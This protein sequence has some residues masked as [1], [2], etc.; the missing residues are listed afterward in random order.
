MKGTRFF[1]HFVSTIVAVL[2]A[3]LS[4]QVSAEE[5]L[6][7]DDTVKRH[8]RK[9]LLQ[10]TDI[11]VTKREFHFDVTYCGHKAPKCHKKGAW[12]Y[13]IGQSLEDEMSNVLLTRLS[14]KRYDALKIKDKK[15]AIETIFEK[16]EI[17][18]DID[19][20]MFDVGNGDDFI[21]KAEAYLNKSIAPL[22]LRLLDKAKDARYQELP[23]KEKETFLATIAKEESVPIKFI[24]SLMSSAYVFTLHMDSL[25]GNV[26]VDQEEKKDSQGR[27]YMVYDTT[28]KVNTNVN[29]LI[30]NFNPNLKKFEFYSKVA[31]RS[32]SV[33][34]SADF[35]HYPD[36]GNTVSLFNKAVRLSA[37]ASGL[38]ANTNLKD[39]DNFAIF[40]TVDQLDGNKIESRIGDVEDLRIDAPY[41]LYQQQDGKRVLVGWVK[42]RSVATEQT[43]KEDIGN[44][45]SKFDL[46]QGEA[47][48]SDSM[49]EHPWTGIF[50]YAGLANSTVT[51]TELDGQSATGGGAYNALNL[52]AK[53]DLGYVFNSASQTEKWLEFNSSFGFGGEDLKT[54]IGNFQGTMAVSASIDLVKRSYMG[55]SGAYWGYKYGIGYSSLSGSR[56]L[57]AENLTVSSYGLNLGLQ[58][59]Y[60][61]SADRS[62]YINVNYM[63]PLASGAS[64]GPTDNPVN[65]DA[66]LSP[67][68]NL[69]VGA[70]FHLRSVG[71]LAGF[72]L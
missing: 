56:V 7:D 34:A 18:S 62:Y 10:L 16:L 68:L 53:L 37:K 19:N 51:L 20:F 57:D 71:S 40:A 44:Y 35:D 3:Q 55:S 13:K 9:V 14:G 58:A 2:I 54:N 70:T 15:I 38:A 26:S 72:M 32:G 21:A 23:D 42:A 61:T 11:G 28:V 66:S 17:D 65:F 48:I 25:T 69:T 60:Q 47:E 67:T 46:I 6:A 27:H 41:N 8:E 63:L 30:F 29:L 64:L 52:G 45:S 1:K 59:G 36:F 24:K 4:F 33:Y 39:D 50:W 49:R 5:L 43:Y 12:V 22:M 31:G